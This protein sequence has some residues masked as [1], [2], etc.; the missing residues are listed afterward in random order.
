LEQA[1]H[2]ALAKAVFHTLRPYG[3][4]A[5]AWGALADRSRIEEIVQ[6]D[7]FPGAQVRQ[8]GE[9][10]LLVRSGPLPGAADWSHAEANAASTGAAEDDFIRPPMAVL[11][12][13][14]TQRWHKFPGQVQVRVAGGRVI[15]FE[16]GLLRAS[17][18]YTGR[19]LWEVEISVGLEP[20]AD[21]LARQ[22]VRYARHRQWGPSPALPAT[23]ELVAIEDA[24][25]LSDG[26]SCL[27][28]DAGHGSADRKHRSSQRHRDAV[29]Q[30]SRQRGFSGGQQRPPC[31]VHAS[32]HGRTAVAG[33]GG[34]GRIELGRGRGQGVLRR[35]GRPAARRGRDPR[36]QPVR[37]EHRHGRARVARPGGAS[38]RY[39]ASLDLVVTPAGFYRGSDGTP[40]PQQSDA[41]R[42]RLVVQGRGLPEAGLPGLIAGQRLLTG[43]EENLLVY[44]IPSAEQIGEPLS[45]S[46]AA[47][48]ARG[49]VRIC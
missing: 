27:V 45:G 35:S 33:R 19:K 32:P 39:S 13:D 15:L 3:G 9:L 48:R 4:V 30:S 8:D 25:Y 38:L 17:D 11:W 28:F 21:P 31:A 20:L 10:V 41:P 44:D 7:A 5:C 46:A 16:E 49:R 34:A 2:L 18:V 29:G 43:D 42:T 1:D 47:V 6:G 24:I 37:A 12:F 14:A 26:T 23:A 22:A 40:V 36:R